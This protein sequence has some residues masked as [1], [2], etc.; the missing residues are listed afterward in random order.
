MAPRDLKQNSLWECVNILRMQDN[1][2]KVHPYFPSAPPTYEDHILRQMKAGTYS[3][4]HQTYVNLEQLRERLRASAKQKEQQNRT[5][6]TPSI[7]HVTS[8]PGQTRDLSAKPSATRDHFVN[9]Q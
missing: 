9:K 1:F 3:G 5:N 4:D 8:N 2:Y 7:H 6:Q